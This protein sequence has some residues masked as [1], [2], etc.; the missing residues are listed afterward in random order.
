[1]LPV[2][3]E[4]YLHMKRVKLSLQHAVEAIGLSDVEVSTF[5]DKRLT[6]GDEA[7]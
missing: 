2:R 1:M 6:G 7:S 3:Y 4:H 5:L